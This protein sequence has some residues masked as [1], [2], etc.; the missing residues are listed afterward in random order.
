MKKNFK[1]FVLLL[2]LTF[3]CPLN[4]SKYTYVYD[5]RMLG[6]KDDRMLGCWDAGMLGCWDAR[7]LGC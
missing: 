6:Y 1:C 7:M 5:A 2:F 3:P 4:R